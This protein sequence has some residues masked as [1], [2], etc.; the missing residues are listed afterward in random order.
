[1]LVFLSKTPAHRNLHAWV[2]SFDRYEVT[3]VAI[4]LVI[5]IFTNS[6]GVEHDQIR[7]SALFELDVASFLEH[8]GKA[9][10]VMDIHLAAVGTHFIGAWGRLIHPN[11]L[12]TGLNPYLPW[13]WHVRQVPWKPW[14]RMF[15]SCTPHS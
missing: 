9:L 7:R 8:A 5:S 15:S 1:M 3:Q 14:K 11:I 6:A 4:E 2:L 13:L 10:R 12:E